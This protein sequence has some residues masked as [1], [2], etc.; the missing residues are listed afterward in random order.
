M[1]DPILY[2]LLVVAISIVVGG[3]YSLFA[4]ISNNRINVETLEESN[5]RL[6]QM[7]KEYQTHKTNN[8]C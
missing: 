1:I 6:I 3:I 8:D 4:V 7:R 2:V 5:E